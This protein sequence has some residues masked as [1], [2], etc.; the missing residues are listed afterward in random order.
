[1]QDTPSSPNRTAEPELVIVAAVARNGVIGAGNALPWRLPADLRRFR[2]LTSGHTVVMGRRTFDS[3]GRPLPGRQNVVVSR[4]PSLRIDGCEVAHSLADA[5]A[6][7]RLPRPVFCIGGAD[8]YRQAL[9]LADRL[10]LTEI[11]ADFPG[12]AHFPA[13]DGREWRECA[14]EAQPPDAA[15]GHA[16]DFV[17]YVRVAHAR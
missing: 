15:S 1:M 5:I 10:E 16:F 9:P 3:I 4:S 14:R 11:R 12:D 6:M 2:A 13:L 17:T 8:L 7:A